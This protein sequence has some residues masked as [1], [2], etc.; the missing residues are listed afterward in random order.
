MTEPHAKLLLQCSQSPQ[1]AAE[2]IESLRL[3]VIALGKPAATRFARKLRLPPGHLHPLHY[4]ILKGVGARMDSFI[5]GKE[6]A[7]G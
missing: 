4:D 7:T 6:E 2:E 1:W 3:A 5:R